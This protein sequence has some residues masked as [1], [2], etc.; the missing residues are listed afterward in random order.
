KICGGEGGWSCGFFL[1]KERVAVELTYCCPPFEDLSV[2][3]PRS[4]AC[5][6]TIPLS[7]ETLKQLGQLSMLK[8]RGVIL[9]AQFETL[10]DHIKAGNCLTKGHWEAIELTWGLKNS[11]VFSE[12]AWKDEVDGQIR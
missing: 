6:E 9:D 11:D 3:G 8:E 1:M 5:R 10:K 7:L 2:C 4:G 12:A